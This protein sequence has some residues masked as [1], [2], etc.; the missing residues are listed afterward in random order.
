MNCI[1]VCP[2]N[3]FDQAEAQ[4]E[5]KIVPRAGVDA[6]YDEALQQIDSTKKSLA[7]YLKEQCKHFGTKV[8]CVCVCVCLYVRERG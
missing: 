5:G 6:E 4:K 2:Q 7:E 1:C 8:R 3:A